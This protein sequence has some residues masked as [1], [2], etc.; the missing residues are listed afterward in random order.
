[1]Q[2]KDSKKLNKEK[3]FEILRKKANEFTQRLERYD[4]FQRSRHSLENATN[5][6]LAIS[7]GTLLW[8][9][10]NFDKFTAPHITTNKSLFL[11]PALF[12]G[13]STIIFALVRGTL[14]LR[15]IGI[16]KA[17]EDIQGLPNRLHLNIE[18]K[19]EE[20]LNE[21]V[22][23]ISNRSIKLWRK[24]HNLMSHTPPLFRAGLIS[25]IA[26]LLLVI[27]YILIFVL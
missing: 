9:L 1:M 26:G 15:Q 8:L 20:E 23:R 21:M 27:I 13:A 14:Y 19:T 10:G 6:I 18:S 11:L 7:A 16:D 25:Y 5:W 2:S 22:N 12:L 17:L 24:S 3:L 4:R